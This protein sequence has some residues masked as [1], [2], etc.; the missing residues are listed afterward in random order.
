LTT[1]P[2][3]AHYAAMRCFTGFDHQ[4]LRVDRD[5]GAPGFAVGGG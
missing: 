1:I 5:I 2:W 3:V 4:V